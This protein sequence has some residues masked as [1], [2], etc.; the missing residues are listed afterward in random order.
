MNPIVRNIQN[1]DLYFYLGENRFKNIRT[2]NE[3][4][5]DDETARKIFRINVD[6][7]EIINE[8]PL[9]IEMIKKINLKIDKPQKQ[10]L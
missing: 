2:D 10:E 3:G 8:F 1:G 5:V 9:V 4:I 7:T 6:A